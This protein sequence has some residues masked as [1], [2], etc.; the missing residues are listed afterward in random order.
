[1]S[2]DFN[3]CPVCKI[4]QIEERYNHE[5]MCPKCYTKYINTPQ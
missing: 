4:E 1:M 2:D 5:G 3:L